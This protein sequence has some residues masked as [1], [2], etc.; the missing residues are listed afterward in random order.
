MTKNSS[1]EQ[2]ADG[3]PPSNTTPSPDSRPDHEKL[4]TGDLRVIQ[5][6]TGEQFEDGTVHAAR[7]RNDE[8]ARRLTEDRA[9]ETV[10]VSSPMRP[11]NDAAAYD[12]TANTQYTA[13]GHT[14]YGL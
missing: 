7:G 6:H 11:Q 12:P 3:T 9:D 2:L 14:S 8:E 5:S 10:D 13:P 4:N 1:S